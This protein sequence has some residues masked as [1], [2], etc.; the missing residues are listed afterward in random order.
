MLKT[1]L[2][3]LVVTEGFFYP[4]LCALKQMLIMMLIKYRSLLAD[5]AKD[6]NKIKFVNLFVSCLGIFG[7]S[8]ESFLQMRSETDIDNRHLKFII[9]KLSKKVIRKTY[10]HI[11]YEE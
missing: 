1:Y 3:H 5:L 4:L 11:L 2:V 6:Y 7:S 8:S 10:F 9:S